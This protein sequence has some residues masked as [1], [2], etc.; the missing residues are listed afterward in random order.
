M[1]DLVLTEMISKSLSGRLEA[2]ERTLLDSQLAKSTATARSFAN[3]SAIIHRS[4]ALVASDEEAMQEHT[5]RL[6]EIAKERLRKSVQSA[7]GRSSIRAAADEGSAE[8]REGALESQVAESR[9]VYFQQPEAERPADSRQAVSRFTLLRKIGEGGLGTVWLARDEKLRRNVALKEMNA[10]AAESPTQW[11]RFQREAE[12]TGHLEHPNVVPLYMSGVNPETG[13][14]FYAMR[15]LGKQTLL[16][17]IHEYHAKRRS[18]SD[19]PIHL[20]RLLNIFLDVCQAIAYAHSRGVVHRDLKPENVALDNFGQVLVLDWGLAKLDTDGELAS[21]FALSGTAAESGLAQTIAGDIVGTPL[22]M[23]PEQAAGE[24]DSLDERTDVYGL[25][26]ILFAILTGYAPHE[27][28]NRSQGGN[29]RVSEFLQSIVQSE[30][31]RPRDVN[32]HVARDLESICMKAMAKQRYARHASAMDLAADVEAWIA[33]KHERQARYD[34]M[35]MNGRDLKS[36]LCVQVRQLAASTQFMVELP[37]VQGLIERLDH[38]DEEYGTW[39]DRMTKILLGL[40]RAKGNVSALSFAQFKDGRIHEIVRVERSLHD[41]SNVRSVPHSRLRRGA[42][43][44]FHK[45]V[46]AQFPGEYCIDMDFATA[47]Q[48]RIVVGVPVFDTETEEPFGMVIS[49]AEIGILVRPE[50]DLIG[51]KDHLYL[52]DDNGQILFSTKRLPG[53]SHGQVS[54]GRDVIDRWSEMIAVLDDEDYVEADREFYATQLSFPQRRNALR[55]V[56][57]VAE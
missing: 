10:A 11:K 35:R 55:I 31:P 28:S 1:N 54:N 23:A 4:V 22:Y 45:T 56:L 14:P 33:G 7:V 53:A 42:A 44:T 46:M 43:N 51:T 6:S 25:G 16:D 48:S 47:G 29:L 38:Q 13:L 3:L 17:A 9:T 39:R 34:A 49:E 2:S 50:L 36:R 30:S 57:Q 24:M 12:I 37:P 32:A 26:A 15:F 8:R 21:R 18:V 20:H 5:E 27:Q 41:V 19:D 40:A 52:L